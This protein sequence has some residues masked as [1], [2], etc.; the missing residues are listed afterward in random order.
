LA[1][2]ALAARAKPPLFAV[3]LPYRR[4]K[5]GSVLLITLLKKNRMFCGLLIYQVFSGLGGG[6]FRL[7]MLLTVHL[8]Y[9]NP[10]Y[11]G[12]ASFLMMAPHFF[13]FAVG[14]VID[15]AN[16]V[17]AMRLT[18]LIEF[19][20]IGLL[21]LMSFLDTLSVW[22]LFVT[23]LC[24]TVAQVFEAPSGEAFL[25]KIVDDDEIMRAN[26]LISI[27]ATVGGLIIAAL[28]FGALGEGVSHTYIYALS[29]IFIVLAFMTTF[30]LKDRKTEGVQ[31]EQIF[32]KYLA[33]LKEGASFVQRTNF[34][35]YF[36]IAGIAVSFFLDVAYT[37]LPEFATTHI[38]AQGFVVITVVMLSAG[39]FSST[40]A[41]LVGDKFRVGVLICLVWIVA[42]SLR[43]GFAYV[44]PMSYIG[45]LVINFV[46]GI[47][48]GFSGMIRRT[49]IQKT[50]SENM[51]ARVNT[52]NTTFTALFGAAGALAG[53]VIG[54][55]VSS[56]HHVFILQGAVYVLIGM[57]LFFAPSIRKLPK[58]NEIKN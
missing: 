19:I 1:L 36:L 39:L 57:F 30:F 14:P 16:K 35:L 46:Y 41:G 32:K 43:I 38:G 51:V 4:R 54:S 9:E 2:S 5:K 42:G 45:G 25:R 31:K 56:V 44:L 29:A 20:A 24:Y 34:L 18:T 22:V 8:L 12:I 58:I 11:T 15:R 3:F 48:L 33:E 55:V 49:L 52:V 17:N 47:I 40:L 13:A 23:I 10:I 21:V 53:G 37:N 27:A 28:L 6:I 50:P 26:S 7:F